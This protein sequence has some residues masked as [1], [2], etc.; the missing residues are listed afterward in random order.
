[1]RVC[2]CVCGGCGDVGGGRRRE[3]KREAR[4][5]ATEA[6]DYRCALAL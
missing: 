4:K 2:V 1:M 6:A 5:S 3:E